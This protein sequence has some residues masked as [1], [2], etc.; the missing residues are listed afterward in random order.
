MN[1]NEILTICIGTYRGPLRVKRN[2]VS[3]RRCF[4]GHVIVGDDGSITAPDGTPDAELIAVA[5]QQS[6]ATLIRSAVNTG[7]P[8]NFNRM[9]GLV[10]TP[11]VLFLDDDALCPPNLPEVVCRL[12]DALP[13]QG[14]G[15]LS[16]V[17]KNITEAAARSFSEK[18]VPVDGTN[19]VPEL[20]TELA[21]FCS[22]YRTDALRAHNGFN[23]EFRYYFADSDL[24][25]RMTKSGELCYRIPWPLIPHVEHSTIH[26]YPELEGDMGR[27]ADRKTFFR[28]WD[29]QPPAVR[30]RLIA[31]EK[32]TS[33][34]GDAQ[35]TIS[36]VL[37]AAFKDW[38]RA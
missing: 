20:D 2:L 21:A 33:E 3:V 27:D 38:A 31:H 9:L 17:S 36:K 10:T 19:L 15:M 16:W 25:V 28:I 12:L 32:G 11:Y 6:S 35:A 30:D 5:A 14:T 8:A 13:T 1:P 7:W 26:V 37:K 18:P 23:P 22:A 29:D 34:H 4:S 24:A